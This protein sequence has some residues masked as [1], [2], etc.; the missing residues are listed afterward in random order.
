[1]LK[2]SLGGP[3]IGPNNMHP[4]AFPSLSVQAPLQDGWSGLS[5]V[6]TQVLV[7]APIQPQAMY[8][9]VVPFARRSTK[10]LFFPPGPGT[11]LNV[12]RDSFGA[13]TS[14][15]SSCLQQQPD[16]FW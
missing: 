16:T 9:P 1:M 7:V 4:C 8:P 2:G 3:T 6:V 11:T 15:R 12:S 10:P 5:E 13:T 14:S